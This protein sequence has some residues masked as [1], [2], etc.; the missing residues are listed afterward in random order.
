MT[1]FARSS[2]SGAWTSLARSKL[3]FR[4]VYQLEPGMKTA[5]KIVLE[6]FVLFVLTFMLSLEHILLANVYDI[7][8]LAYLFVA[9]YCMCCWLSHRSCGIHK[10]QY[11]VVITALACIVS[12]FSVERI[13]FKDEKGCE[14]W[15]LKAIETNSRRKNRVMK[16]HPST[17]EQSF[18]AAINMLSQY[19]NDE[20]V[21][22]IREL[23]DVETLRIISFTASIASWPMRAG[24]DVEFDNRMDGISQAAMHKLFLSDSDLA[25]EAIEY[26]KRIF[27]LDGAHSLFFKECEEERRF[28]KG[29]EPCR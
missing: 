12:F 14:D 22:E 4:N 26:Y 10:V 29:S 28:R 16:E 9:V 6:S 21:M 23:E 20:I 7:P 17:K 18:A 11:G 19:S 5:C 25:G 27:P 13:L 2:I 8:C 3:D 24:P 15:I 1:R